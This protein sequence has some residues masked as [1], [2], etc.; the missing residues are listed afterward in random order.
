MT[1]PNGRW[2]GTRPSMSSAA[3]GGFTGRM[4]ARGTWYM[5]RRPPMRFPRFGWIAVAGLAVDILSNRPARIAPATNAVTGLPYDWSGWTLI[6]GPSP[7]PTP[8][9]HGY[10][11]QWVFFG[12]GGGCATPQCGLAGIAYGA[13]VWN[14]AASIAPPGADCARLY[15]G[16]APALLP[17]R[18]YYQVEQRSRPGGGPIPLVIAV[19]AV[20]PYTGTTVA[21][22]Q[23][24]DRP[25]M[26]S[27]G[28]IPVPV[29]VVSYTPLPTWPEQTDRGWRLPPVGYPPIGIPVDAPRPAPP[30]SG[31]RP[32]TPDIVKP[33]PWWVDVKSPPFDREVKMADASGRMATLFKTLSFWGSA[34][35]II[36]ALWRSL[37]SYARTAH[38]RTAQKYADVFRAFGTG[39]INADAFT[40][41]VGYWLGYKAAGQLYGTA[42]RAVAGIGHGGYQLYRAW[43][44]GEYVGSSAGVLFRGT[45]SE[46]PA[47]Q[48]SRTTVSYRGARTIERQYQRDLRGIE[49]DFRAGFV[50]GTRRQ[51]SYATQ[52]RRRRIR[53]LNQ[54]RQR[55]LIRHGHGE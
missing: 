26:T 4:P 39:E 1:Y 44:T 49:R 50:G 31:G 7:S 35:S 23:P 15:Q 6:C 40:N 12:P 9:V 47:A 29:R 25:G 14:N 43:A 19:P 48:A 32:T 54:R 13:N 3:L 36:D 42:F 46:R 51:K 30:G 21:V 52:L 27:V 22:G 53:Q 20:V 33:Y 5:P 38:A 28:V 55:S 17:L 37:P 8:A 11:M 16:P 10:Q 2:R 41:A 45:A 18:R 34:N 24:V